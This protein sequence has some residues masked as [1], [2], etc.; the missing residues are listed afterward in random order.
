MKRHLFIGGIFLFLLWA[1]PLYAQQDPSKLVDLLDLRNPVKTN[2]LG[3]PLQ[4]MFLMSFLTILPFLVIMTTS[5][6]RTVI[7]LSFLK[8]AI[9]TQQV[10]PSQVI[11]G[12]A[13]FLSIYTMSP[14]WRE[15]DEKALQPYM[16]RE[17]TQKEALEKTLSPLRTFM[18]RQTGKKELA[19]FIRTVR[20]PQPKN[21][22][23]VPTH[24]L[25]PAFMIS[26]LSTAFK[27][28]FVLYLP[29]L[30]VDLVVANTL[31]ALGMMMLSPVTISM[32]FKLLIFTLADGWN[33]I[34]KALVESFYI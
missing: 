32:P 26:E 25:I 14:V 7:V 3:T 10:P 11:V 28:G 12:L 34:I 30:V 16:N 22:K 20:L 1:T 23:E 6:T 4:L 29:F 2:E 24:V 17:I 27:I 15:I 33:I 21:Q 19:F 5:F 9:G 31:L 18:F 8:N 13:I